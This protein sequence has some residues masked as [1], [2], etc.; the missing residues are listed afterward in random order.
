[1][2][3]K[4]GFAGNYNNS[5]RVQDTMGLRLLFICIFFAPFT[6]F[7]QKDVRTLGVLPQEISETS[8]LIFHNG[9][10]ITHNDSGNEARLFEIDTLSLKITRTVTIKNADNVDWE[11]I[12]QDDTYI[13]IGDFGNN[14]G[15][16]SDLV[17]YRI[18]KSEYE[19]FNEVSAD[20]I[21]FSFED[22]SSFVEN[23]N[24]DWDAEALFAFGNTLVVLT[25][26]WGSKG[27]VAYVLP[28]LPGDYSAKRLDGYQVN[29]LI[30]GSAYNST[31]KLLYLIGYSNT[32]KPFIV[33]VEGANENAIFGGKIEKTNLNINLVQVEGI[34]HVTGDTYFLSSELFI[35]DNPS[36]LSEARLFSF[37]SGDEKEEN[38]EEFPIE[39][40]E[41]SSEAKKEKLIVYRAFGSNTLN[42]KLTTES[43]IFGRAIFDSAG[44]RVQYMLGADLEGNT[45]DVSTLKPS[46][47]YLAFYLSDKIISTPFLKY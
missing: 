11:D 45:L 20:R 1:M 5:R 25:K 40:P 24:S 21:D 26:Q 41:T 46:I 27:T 16:R 30:T 2:G 47:Y 37:E 15:S 38:E 12:T 9:K 14:N 31:A 35:R 39:D 3:A 32:L 6:I 34:S 17:I 22:Q 44:K 19:Q 42:Y 33:R 36:I 4:G 43:S 29:G 18:A 8:G 28:S 10:L 13:Y 7:S 23:S